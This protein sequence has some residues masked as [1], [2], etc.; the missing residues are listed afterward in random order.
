[1]AY[2]ESL[3]M[4]AAA[5]A[6]V[7]DSGT[8]QDEASALGVPCFTLRSMTERAITLSH[9]TNAL[10]GSDPRG[11]ADVR[12]RPGG[13]T[14]CAIPLWDGGAAGRAAGV[15]LAGYAFERVARAS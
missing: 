8:M 3:S 2:V 7:T 14:P 6:I 11:L 9:G 4:Q 1:M 10:L 15:L 13:P 5:G 12:L